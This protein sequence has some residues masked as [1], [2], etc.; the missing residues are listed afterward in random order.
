MEAVSSWAFAYRCCPLLPARC[1][2]SAGQTRATPAVR[3]T[4][5]V[6]TRW[7]RML[8]SASF[9]TVT[10]PVVTSTQA[11]ASRRRPASQPASDRARSSGPPAPAGCAGPQPATARLPRRRAWRRRQGRSSAAPWLGCRSWPALGRPRRSRRRRPMGHV[12]STR[13][14]AEP[15]G[16]VEVCLGLL[17]AEP[18]PALWISTRVVS[19]RAVRLRGR[20]LR[21]AR[22][23]RS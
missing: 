9:T 8:V 19:R 22:R 23:R 10:R 14:R 21:I 20:Q 13:R 1:S 4:S 18:D 5:A 6:S 16:P 15:A 11:E 17:A 3:T 12:G 7:T 2:S